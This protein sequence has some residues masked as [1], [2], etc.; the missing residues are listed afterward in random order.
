MRKEVEEQRA[1]GW[2]KRDIKSRNEGIGNNRSCLDISFASS[3]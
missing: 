1:S 3:C 2:R